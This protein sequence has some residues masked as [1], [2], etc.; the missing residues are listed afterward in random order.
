MELNPKH[1]SAANNLAWIYAEQGENIDRALELAIIAKENNPEN[2]LISDTLGWAY[3]KK[4]LYLK[5]VS[6]LKE[7][8][9][10]VNNNPTIHYHLG[11]AYAKRGEP[12]DKKLA[13]QSLQKALKID[14]RF[15][16]A[17][18]AKKTLESL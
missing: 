16:G 6:L 8:T 11:M 4:G 9:E 14:S 12:G 10:K 1:P 5:A 17:D 13:Q 3:Y 18:I 2:P 15:I 7:S